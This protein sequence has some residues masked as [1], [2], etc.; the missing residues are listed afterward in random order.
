MKVSE[1]DGGTLLGGSD[2]NPLNGTM[3]D[4]R[5]LGCSVSNK[6]LTQYIK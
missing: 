3:R 6:D 4:A 2:G 1:S 5:L